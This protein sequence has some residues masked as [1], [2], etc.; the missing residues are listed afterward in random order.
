M[1]PAKSTTV[2]DGQLAE[3]RAKA[4]AASAHC[5]EVERGDPLKPGWD[6]EFLAAETAVKATARGVEALEALRAAQLERSGVRAAAVKAAGPDLKA[7]ASALAASRDTIA[8]A[9]AEH[10]RAFA[11][12]VA[13]AEAHNAA[14]AG[15]RSQLAAKG[16]RVKDELVDEGQEHEQG[17]MDA[18][19][20]AGGTDWTPVPAAGV[21]A[22]ALRQVFGA[23]SPLHPLA[24]VGR[25]TWRAHDVEARPDGLRLPTLE[26]VGATMPERP[27]PVVARSTPV[28]DLLPAREVVPGQDRSGY[29]PSPRPGL[30]KIMSTRSRENG[31]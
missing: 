2:T 8:A 21:A 1:N 26:D 19:L 4:E 14:L 17:A 28:A 7:S 20:R 29:F 6:A 10:L 3:A 25:F 22:F 30:P 16:L 23:E 12:L 18:G 15:F 5:R 24:Q 31:R 13:A 27:R 11:G 9:A